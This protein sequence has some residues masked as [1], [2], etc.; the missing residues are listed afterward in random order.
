[1]TGESVS[2][3][4]LYPELPHQPSF[5]VVNKKLKTAGIQKDLITVGL[6]QCSDNLPRRKYLDDQFS[7]V[8]ENNFNLKEVERELKKVTVPKYQ[9]LTNHNKTFY[10]CTSA[11]SISR[12]RPAKNVIE[13][14][15]AVIELQRD[16]TFW[17]EMKPTIDTSQITKSK[18]IK[19]HCIFTVC[20]TKKQPKKIFSKQRRATAPCV[21]TLS[22]PEIYVQ[23]D[24]DIQYRLNPMEKTVFSSLPCSPRPKRRSSLRPNSAFAVNNQT[25]I[26]D[27]RQSSPSNIYNNGP[28]KLTYEEWLTLKDNEQRRQSIDALR[29]FKLEQIDEHYKSL[30]RLSHGKTYDEWKEGKEKYYREKQKEEKRKENE[31]KKSKSEDDKQHEKLTERKYNEWLKKKYEEEVSAELALMQKLSLN[32]KE[33]SSVSKRG[34]NKFQRAQS[35]H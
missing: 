2:S 23:T 4:L 25:K 11:E 35:I 8:P 16:Q 5:G 9:T 30:E 34:R 22:T 14:E 33:N 28:T 17:E 27:R 12:R 26:L 10:R 1:M 18:N 32:G 19:H 3:N 13:E 20:G 21:T 29:A 31:L 24:E 7:I 6:Q 15:S